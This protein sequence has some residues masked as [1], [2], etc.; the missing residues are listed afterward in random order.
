MLAEVEGRILA[1]NSKRPSTVVWKGGLYIKAGIDGIQLNCLVDTGANRSITHPSKY[2]GIS[3]YCR[4]TLKPTDQRIR[5]PNGNKIEPLGEAIVP[6]K[7]GAYTIHHQLLVA[8]IEEPLV[9]GNDFLFENNGIIDI[10]NRVLSLSGKTIPCYLEDELPSIFR[11]RL[12]SDLVVPPSCEI[13]LP[14]YIQSSVMTVLPKNLILE[15]SEKLMENKGVIVA[16][17]LVDSQTHTIPVHVLN[18][19]EKEVQL[20]KETILGIGHQVLEINEGR[21]YSTKSDISDHTIP[22]YLIPLVDGCRGKLDEERI[23]KVTKLISEF[24]DIFSKSKDDLGHT[25]I[26]EHRIDTGNATPIKQQPRRLPLSKRQAERDEVQRMLKSDVIEPSSSPWASPIVMV[27]KKDGSIR[28]CVDY[29]KLNGVTLRDSYPLP[30]I[31]DCLDSLRGAKWFSTLDLASGYWQ[32]GV[33]PDDREKTAFT[34]QSGLFP[35]KVLPFGLTNAP[36]SFERLMEKVLAGLQFDICL[37]YLDDVIV[38]SDEFDSHITHLRSVFERIRKAN[39]KLSPKK[40]V[41][42]QQKVQFLG[43]IITQDGISTDPKKVE[44]VQN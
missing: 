17:V 39:L 3:D 21:C 36:S 6:L 34:C 12:A 31:D 22:S 25:N 19:H 24:T 4:P 18:P 15:G 20:Y 27:T 10:G 5:V 23:G 26:E 43:H 40:Y 2:F 29:R 14:A 16:R 11:I 7:F 8:E 1:G 13:I 30:R 42:F 28:F 9:L 33:H 44:T 38:K 37:I 41:L 32:M 35:F